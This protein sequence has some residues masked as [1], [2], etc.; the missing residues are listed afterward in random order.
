MKC[1]NCGE[2]TP[3]AA[4]N[5]PKCHVIFSKL[6]ERSMRKALEAH[7]ELRKE[8]AG[9]AS[10][11]MFRLFVMFLVTAAI[12]F[13][14]QHSHK[15]PAAAAQRPGQ[16]ARPAAAIKNP[17]KLEGHVAD[18]LRGKPVSGVKVV[19]SAPGP[20]ERFSAETDFRGYYSLDLKPLA[21]G[22]YAVELDHPDY[23]DRWWDAKYLK[24]NKKRRYELSNQQ[25]PPD[26][27]GRRAGKAGTTLKYDFLIFPKE[28]AKEEKREL[29]GED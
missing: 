4:E 27:S 6:H 16:E 18:M 26:E 13:Y 9:D 21:E 19:F 5:C 14:L 1:P 25:Q 2:E 7:A 20:E 17:W 23:G 28:L 24:L 29:L 12:Y 8:P 15:P 10:S 3:Q 22:G 11:P